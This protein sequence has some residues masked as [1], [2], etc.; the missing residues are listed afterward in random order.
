MLPF[1][2][3]MKDAQFDLF[4]TNFLV[5]HMK[6]TCI[7][8]MGVKLIKNIESWSL[9]FSC[10][11]L[12]HFPLISENHKWSYYCSKDALGGDCAP[13]F[14]NLQVPSTKNQHPLLL[15]MEE[16]PNNLPGKHEEPTRSTRACTCTLL[17]SNMI[18]TN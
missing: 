2:I 17:D 9:W 1:I 18:Q 4:G 10:W 5:S 7:K 6:T 12:L 13:I 8:V 16:Q 14:Q 11:G 15:E 3:P